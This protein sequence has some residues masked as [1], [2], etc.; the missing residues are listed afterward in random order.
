MRLA[1]GANINFYSLAV[2]KNPYNLEFA[3]QF[4]ALIILPLESHK[5]SFRF[6]FIIRRSNAIN[7]HA[8]T[9]SLFF[10]VFFPLKWLSIGFSSTLHSIAFF[11]ICNSV[12]L[13]FSATNFGNVFHWCVKKKRKWKHKMKKKLLCHTFDWNDCSALE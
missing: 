10:V 3:P 12:S 8:L 13:F 11:H 5:F 7:Q 1:Q 9:D 6:L 4:W 2:T